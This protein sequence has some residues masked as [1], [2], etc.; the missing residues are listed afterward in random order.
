M[1]KVL[2]NTLDLC[3][4]ECYDRYVLSGELMIKFFFFAISQF[5]I[6]ILKYMLYNG[7]FDLVDLVS[8]VDIN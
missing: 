4:S 6:F 1:F 3:E 7:D 5:I 2:S 8:D